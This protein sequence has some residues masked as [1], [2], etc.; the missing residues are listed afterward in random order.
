M[1]HQTRVKK[2]ILQGT[3]PE[4][5]FQIVDEDGVG[6]Q[7]AALT[8]SIYDVDFGLVW[9]SSLPPALPS[10]VTQAIVN[11]RNDVDILADCDVDGNVAFTL[12][13]DDTD[14]TVPDAAVPSFLCRRL[15]FRWTWDTT[16]VGKHEVILTIA[17]DRETV[18]S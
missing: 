15:L 3:T 10:T 9:P 12:E 2:A 1:S 13:A 17:P 16:K 6:F 8:V 4:V 7:P 5:T 14:V 11:S 18:A